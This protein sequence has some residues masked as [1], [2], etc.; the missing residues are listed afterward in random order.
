M[1][2]S[3]DITAVS[4]L[5]VVTADGCRAQPRA[6]LWCG[7]NQCTKQ[8]YSEH[9]CQSTE[10]AAHLCSL[11]HFTVSYKT[12]TSLIATVRLTY[13]VCLYCTLSNNRW[14]EPLGLCRRLQSA[15]L[16]PL[17]WCLRCQW[18]QWLLSSDSCCPTTAVH[19]ALFS[20]AV[21]Q[22]MCSCTVESNNAVGFCC[23]KQY[24]Y[25]M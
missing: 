16:S 25:Y 8:Q 24:Q 21:L 17:S 9:F 18:W 1:A 5:C 15:S 4:S 12:V 23:D 3:T 7:A 13:A 2:V 11:S 20:G 14:C 22:R 19:A 6:L 10:R